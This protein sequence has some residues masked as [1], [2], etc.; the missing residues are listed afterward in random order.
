[1]L[2]KTASTQRL[3]SPTG[4]LG[5]HLQETGGFNEWLKPRCPLNLNLV[6]VVHLVAGYIMVAGS[7]YIGSLEI[8]R[9]NSAFRYR[10][11]ITTE[12]GR[13]EAKE[14]LVRNKLGKGADLRLS[15]RCWLDS[16]RLQRETVALHSL[17]QVWLSMG[18]MEARSSKRMTTI[19]FWCP[20]LGREVQMEC[21]LEENTMLPI[22][23]IAK[24]QTCLEFHKRGCTYY[25]DPNCLVGKEIQGNFLKKVAAS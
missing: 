24:P 5:S 21:F 16:A 4:S 25:E 12:M 6:A 22:I 7:D 17:S 10:S 1:M 8:R 19:T 2:E 14:L 9:Q 11:G 20:C 15:T 3:R 23:Q 13:A 18:C